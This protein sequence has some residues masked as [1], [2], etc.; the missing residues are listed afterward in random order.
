M[1]AKVCFGC[2]MRHIFDAMHELVELNE[3]GEAFRVYHVDCAPKTAIA[4]PLQFVQR[5]YGVEEAERLAEKANN[6]RFQRGEDYEK[7]LAVQEEANQKAVREEEEAKSNVV[8][9]EV[10]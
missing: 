4:T 2:S 9:L 6:R 1:V 7:E 10:S 8:E 5:G 3:E